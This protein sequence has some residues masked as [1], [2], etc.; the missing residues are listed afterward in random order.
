MNYFL[1]DYKNDL[2]QKEVAATENTRNPGEELSTLEYG[3]EL[4]RQ[5]NVMQQAPRPPFETIK[6]LQERLERENELYR[7]QFIW[8]MENMIRFTT[9]AQ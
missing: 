2:E 3:K 4:E 9:N 8:Q 6:H 5:I 1:Q 7:K